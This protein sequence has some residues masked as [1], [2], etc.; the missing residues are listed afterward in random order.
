MIPHAFPVAERPAEL[1][2]ASQA[3]LD[4]GDFSGKPWPNGSTPMT[5]AISRNG[6]WRVR[7]LTWSRRSRPPISCAGALRIVSPEHP[8]QAAS[9]AVLRTCK[10]ITL[11][12]VLAFADALI[13]D[14]PLSKPRLKAW[15]FKA[16]PAGARVPFCTGVGRPANDFQKVGEWRSRAA[17]YFVNSKT[18]TRKCHGW[19]DG[20][21]SGYASN[22]AGERRRC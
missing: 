19:T 7:E 13:Q 10:R 15:G 1:L 22:A 18:Q 3:Q 21:R 14:A 17:A 9:L 8:P 6:R 4:V 11:P 16:S 12:K 5:A 20:A 2:Q